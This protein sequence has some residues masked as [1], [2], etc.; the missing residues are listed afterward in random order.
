MTKCRIIDSINY[1]RNRVIVDAVKNKTF[2]FRYP[3]SNALHSRAFAKKEI[4]VSSRVSTIAMYHYWLAQKP[5]WL[6]LF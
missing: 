4:R 1:H 2:L 6:F 5:P 3:V